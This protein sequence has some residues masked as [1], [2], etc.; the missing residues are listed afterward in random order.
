MNFSEY[1]YAKTLCET[2]LVVR[3]KHLDMLFEKVKKGELKVGNDLFI[4]CFKNPVMYGELVLKIR[5]Y[6]KEQEST[7]I[8]SV[9]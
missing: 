1:E 6:R 9:E 8:L 7:K 5:D 4:L 3:A 2:D